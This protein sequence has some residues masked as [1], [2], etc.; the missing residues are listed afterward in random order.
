[1]IIYKKTPFNCQMRNM[2][3]LDAGN[4]DDIIYVNRETYDQALSVSIMFS[5][6]ITRV[7]TQLTHAVK[8]YSDRQEENNLI[9]WLYEK[10]PQP[11]RI[12][13]PFIMMSRDAEFDW[14]VDDAKKLEQAYG[15]IHTISMFT[16]MYNM[17]KIPVEVMAKIEL[18][19]HVLK[20]YQNSWDMLTK[21]LE[22][23]VVYPQIKHDEENPDVV[24]VPMPFM[25]VKGNP[26][27]MPQFDTPVVQQPAQQVV[28][29]TPVQA[30]VQTPAQATVQTSS[31]LDA[32]IAEQPKP[33]VED[34]GD[35][36]ADPDEIQK[37]M[38]RI[39]NQ[40]IEELREKYKK[41]NE[42]EKLERQAKEEVHMN[43]KQQREK[44]I[45]DQSNKLLDEYAGL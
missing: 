25:Q 32:I 1:M 26:I 43:E 14:N 7:K 13:A 41:N 39:K 22:D 5:D 44:D 2:I 10:M 35:G 27:V 36:V 4:E 21:G 15:I 33:A 34:S 40:P 23:E 3:I 30:V 20:G 31:A 45:A 38:E 6:D 9:N 12:L 29:Q 28:V 19:K 16:D 42:S 24:Y 11:I 17:F 8:N 18:P 37:I